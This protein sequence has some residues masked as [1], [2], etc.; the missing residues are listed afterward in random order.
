MVLKI[1]FKTKSF[2][3]NDFT[4]ETKWKE[5]LE[6]SFSVADWKKLWEKINTAT[7]DVEESD[8]ENDDLD[9]TNIP[10]LYMPWTEEEK[11]ILG[12]LTT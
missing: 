7:L 11:R 1:V 3:Y 10:K 5:I 8:S 2:D 6:S 12:P 9:V 4:F